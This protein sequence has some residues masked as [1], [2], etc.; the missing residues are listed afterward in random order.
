MKSLKV[1]EW[2]KLHYEDKKHKDGVAIK[3]RTDKSSWN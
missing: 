1:N 3:S 2:K